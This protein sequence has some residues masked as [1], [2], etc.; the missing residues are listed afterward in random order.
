MD[1][2]SSFIEEPCAL[3]M[4]LKD[5]TAGISRNSNLIY[6]RRD[7]IVAFFKI[8][9]LFKFRYVTVKARISLQVF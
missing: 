7:D 3:T 5:E 6:F 1:L 9:Q 8:E 2:I 4:V